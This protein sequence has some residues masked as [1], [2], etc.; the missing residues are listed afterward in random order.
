VSAVAVATSSMWTHDTMPLPVTAGIAHHFT[1][2][3]NISSC[4][5]PGP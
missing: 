3:V 4:G 1:S 2:L 5:T